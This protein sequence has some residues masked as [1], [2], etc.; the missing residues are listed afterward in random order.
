MSCMEVDTL[1]CNEPAVYQA[2]FV[3]SYFGF[4]TD[5]IVRDQE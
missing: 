1:L 4:N 2:C 3:A 5:N